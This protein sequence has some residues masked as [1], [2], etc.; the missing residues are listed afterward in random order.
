MGIMRRRTPF[1][2]WAVAVLSLLA[3]DLDA[4]PDDAGPAPGAPAPRISVDRTE[5]DY[6]AVRQGEKRTTTFAV[7]NV[8]IGPLHVTA[9]ADSGS[10]GVTVAAKG[11]EPGEA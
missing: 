8:G 11:T 4:R 10:M 9:R 1:A 6:G 7:K 3:R 5:H 2:P